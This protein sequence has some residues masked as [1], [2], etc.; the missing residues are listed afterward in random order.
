MKI[1]LSPLKVYEYG[2]CGKPVV[3][4]R[5]KNLE[6]IEQ[7]NIGKLVNPEDPKELAIAIKTMLG[8]PEEGKIM[9]MNARMLMEEKYNWDSIAQLIQIKID[10]IINL[11]D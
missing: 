9:G 8:N 4:S 7:N 3:A 10:D 6:F 2:A 1:G 5:I 11:H